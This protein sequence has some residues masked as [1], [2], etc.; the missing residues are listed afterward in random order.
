MEPKI[1]KRL[2]I[3][4]LTPQISSS[5]LSGRFSSFGTVKAL[6]G[7]GKLDAV[8]LPRRYAYITLESTK[9]QLAKCTTSSTYYSYLIN[10][11][12]LGLNVLSGTTWKG[13]KLRIGEAKPDFYERCV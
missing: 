4:G 11:L 12:F 3:S 7:L 2:H 5:D 1:V 9:E 6:D 10:N 13:A 8:G